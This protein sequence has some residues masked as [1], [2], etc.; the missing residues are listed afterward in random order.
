MNNCPSLVDLNTCTILFVGGILL[1]RR[2]VTLIYYEGTNCLV[3]LPLSPSPLPSSHLCVVDIYR[4]YYVNKLVGGLFL[5][6]IY[7]YIIVRR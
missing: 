3:S 2:V 5:L 7:I 6:S 4:Y 1:A